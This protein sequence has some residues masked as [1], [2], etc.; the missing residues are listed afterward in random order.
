MAKTVIDALKEA[1]EGLLYPSESDEPFE[2]ISWGK[3]QGDLLPDKVRQLTGAAAGTSIEEVAP[4]DFFAN[5]T[6]Q[7]EGAPDEE[8]PKK[9]AL[10]QSIFDKH[11]S[12]VKV[13]RVGKVNIAVYIVGETKDGEWVGLKTQSVET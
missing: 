9:F 7:V 10:L 4:R 8:D 13:F 1:S 12:Q 5:L 11:L 3:V 6:Q 2:P